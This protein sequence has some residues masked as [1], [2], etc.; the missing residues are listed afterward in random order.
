LDLAERTR[1]VFLTGQ[2]S[3]HATDLLGFVTDTL[4][5]GDGLGDGEYQSQISR[6]WL[7][8]RQ[9]LGAFFVDGHFHGVDF[10]V[11]ASNFLA[12]LAVAFDES[13]HAVGNLMLDQ[14]THGEYTLADVFEF[15]I[16]LCRG[17]FLDADFIVQCHS[18]LPGCVP[19]ALSR[20]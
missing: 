6:L 19:S 5:V 14:S 20:S 4:Q 18:R 12:E 13:L 3:R 10:V 15:D 9:N 8:A 1:G 17:V 2:L 7:P 16:K 11:A